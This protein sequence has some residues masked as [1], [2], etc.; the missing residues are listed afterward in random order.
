MCGPLALLVFE[1]VRYRMRF[2]EREA[3]A[4]LPDVRPLLGEPAVSRN[5]PVG[6]PAWHRALWAEFGLD[7]D[8]VARVEA[9]GRS[10]R[11]EAEP[12][13]MVL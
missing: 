6:D 10:L 9:F 4:Y 12:G 8:D 11:F 7:A 2:L 1:S 5:G 13:R 3:F